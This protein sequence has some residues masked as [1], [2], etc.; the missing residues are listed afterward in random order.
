[1]TEDIKCWK[2]VPNGP[3]DSDKEMCDLCEGTGKI[4]GDDGEF[5][6]CPNFSNPREEDMYEQT[7]LQD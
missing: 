3:E 2:I 1:M 4:E 6:V 7:R 5:S